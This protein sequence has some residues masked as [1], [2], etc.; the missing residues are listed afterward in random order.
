MGGQ[1]SSF[2]YPNA[3]PLTYLPTTPARSPPPLNPCLLGPGGVRPS[4]CSPLAPRPARSNPPPRRPP[5]SGATAAATPAAATPAPPAPP[6][7]RQLTALGKQHA[8][9]LAD[10]RRDC[11]VEVKL[12]NRAYTNLQ[13][14]AAAEQ[15]V[16]GTRRDAVAAW[17]TASE[18]QAPGSR[19][20][21]AIPSN[22]TL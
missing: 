10:V 16:T 9:Q 20:R 7:H 2:E 3:P 15:A 21:R 14:M 17:P 11:A 18:R 4:L 13:A 6:E 12:V 5:A 19:G 8:A 1:A 22:L